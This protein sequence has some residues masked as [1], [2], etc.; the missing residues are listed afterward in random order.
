M[1][2]RLSL[3][4]FGLLLLLELVSVLSLWSLNSTTLAGETVFGLLLAVSLVSFALISYIYRMDK[5]GDRVNRG[6]VLVGCVMVL[7]LLFTG[8]FVAS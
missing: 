8:L 2:D 6:V 1:T 4:V 5:W 3:R 7:A